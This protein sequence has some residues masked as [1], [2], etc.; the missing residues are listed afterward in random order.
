MR[1]TVRRSLV[2]AG[3]ALLVACES[4]RLGGP[5]GSAGGTGT[6]GG[7]SGSGL[8]GTWRR[9]LLFVAEDGSTGSNET[10][11]RFNANLTA[12]R[13]TVTRN[14]TSGLSD[15]QV[16]EAL[17]EPLP[18]SVRITYLPPSSGTFEFPYRITA[19]TLFLASQAYGRVGP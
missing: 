3:A 16:V 1:L 18:Q 9:I 6:A 14:F 5:L 15:A 19:D 7:A 10:T 8:V 13:L 2:L 12:S 4:S 11:W 17:W